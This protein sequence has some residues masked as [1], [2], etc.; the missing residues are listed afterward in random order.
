MDITKLKLPRKP[1]TINN[2][3]T[4]IAASYKIRISCCSMNDKLIYAWDQYLGIISLLLGLLVYG[5]FV[6][7]MLGIIGLQL[8]TECTSKVQRLQV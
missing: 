5:Q 2:V 8:Q 7:I 1:T 3:A 6:L 4:T